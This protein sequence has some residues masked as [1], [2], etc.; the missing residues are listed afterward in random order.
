[1]VERIACGINNCFIVSNPQ[2]GSAILVD[3]AQEK[4]R[5]KVLEACKGR[6]VTLIVL[7]HGHYDHAQNAAWLAEKLGVPVAMHPAD[8]PVL[9]DILHESLRYVD[10][11]SFML[12][13][14]LKLSLHPGFGWIAKCLGA[15]VDPFGPVV[16]LR[17]GASLAA[18][19]VDATV[20]ELPGHS[21][22]SIG[23]AAGNDLLVGDALT[24]LF[25][26]SKA[27]IFSDKEAMLRSAEKISAYGE[28]VMIHFGHGKSL[29]NR[30]AW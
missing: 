7:T 19:G 5:D 18:Y 28:G 23:V 2:G 8:V 3:T 17:E 9:S 10:F 12:I 6:N 20:L 26:T 21:A 27:V 14:L 30:K 13:N 25:Y 15:H 4:Y 16:E 22:G 1:M 29:R 24:N 11:T